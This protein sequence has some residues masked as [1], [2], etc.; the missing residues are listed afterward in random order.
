MTG[1]KQRGNN[2]M[3]A[4]GERSKQ[5]GWVRKHN[6]MDQ[7]VEWTCSNKAY[8]VFTGGQLGLVMARVGGQI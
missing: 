7:G 6:S 3:S 1:S 4:Y 8:K 5:G 2:M